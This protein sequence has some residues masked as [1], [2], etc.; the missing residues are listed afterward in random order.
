MAAVGLER[1]LSSECS[2]RGG[3]LQGQLSQER[4]WAVAWPSAACP[5]GSGSLKAPDLDPELSLNWLLPRVDQDSALH[6][7]LQILKEKEGADFILLNFSFKV[8]PSFPVLPGPR[9]P[10]HLP[11]LQRA[12]TSPP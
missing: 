4:V 10:F 5:R 9:Y 6:N 11:V 12:L 8:S 3:S 2:H 7:D 1:K